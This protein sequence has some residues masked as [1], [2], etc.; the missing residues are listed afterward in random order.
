MEMGAKVLQL[1]DTFLTLLVS[2]VD[3]QFKLGLLSTLRHFCEQLWFS[4]VEESGQY[5][6][7]F[8]T[9]AMKILWS[10][11]TKIYQLAENMANRKEKLR[12]EAYL[13]MAQILKIS[14]EDFLKQNLMKFL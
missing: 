8:D 14:T 5:V 3:S 1:F 12:E 9:E 7:T 2:K 4:S 13:L 11:V 10:T 6:N